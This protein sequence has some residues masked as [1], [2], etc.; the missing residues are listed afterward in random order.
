MRGSKSEMVMQAREIAKKVADDLI[1]GVPGETVHKIDI[2]THYNIPYAK[3]VV[4]FV[5]L[6]EYG[7]EVARTEIKVPDAQTPAPA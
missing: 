4:V 7:F 5:L 1:K 3:S 2:R 6:R